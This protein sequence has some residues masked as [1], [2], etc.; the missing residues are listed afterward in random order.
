MATRASVWSMTIEPP[1]LQRDLAL[2]DLGDLLV[3]LVLVEQRL[4]A[5]VQLQRLDVP[6]MTRC[7][8][9]LARSYAC[10]LVDVDR[11]DVAVKMSRIVRMIMSLSS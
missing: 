7:R 6:G 9:S 2:V 1:C 8:N 10:G 5:F 11:V 4:L 3:E